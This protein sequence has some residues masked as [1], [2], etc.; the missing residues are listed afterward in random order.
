[1]MRSYATLALVGLGLL[2]AGC[3]GGA[4]P[5]GELLVYCAAALRVPVEA[6]AR[7]YEAEHGV[8]VQLQYGGS[9]TLL[10]NI[11][12]S[13][14]GDLYI[15]ADDDYLTLAR[16]KGLIDEQLLL[17]VMRPVLA[18]KKDGGP[19]VESLAAL[20]PGIK[21]ALANP[22]T[23]AV[24]RLTREALGRDAYAR[25]AAR[26]P[27][28]KETVTEV[29]LAVKLG[30]ADAGIVWDATVAQMPE[31]R[32]IA[33]PELKGQKATVSAGVLRTSENPT[34]AL[35][36]ARYLAAADKG[37]N[38]F[39]DNGYETAEGDPWADKPELKLM[40]GAMLR[41]AVEQTLNDFEQREDV[42]IT[43]V[44][45]GCGLLTAQMKASGPP[46]A[47]FACDGCFLD[48]RYEPEI[49]ALFHE[50]VRVS[51]NDIV[52]GVARGNPRGIQ[53]LA[54]LGRD[55]LR[56]GVGHPEQSALGR[57][58]ERLLK[59]AKLDEALRPNVRVE[60]AT[61][62]YLINQLRVGS[63]DAV[64]AYRSNVVG[65]DQLEAVD[66]PL[67]SAQAE[68]PFVIARSCRYPQ[69]TRRLLDRIRSAESQKRFQAAG[70]RW[71]G[72]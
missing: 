14:K 62:D 67:A 63:L 40:C 52:I 20:P 35:R 60:S 29:A 39:R 45:N 69:L 50:P 66:I 22:D 6:A 38:D 31:L 46:D 68:Q 23:A 55:G 34:A 4:A 37:Q 43:R 58:T 10:A 44:Y 11:E 2:A 26:E 27:A 49:A 41:P 13:K 32:A 19:A 53:K 5:K 36:F 17:A 21:L 9:Q 25:L 71:A 64:I 1:M 59:E 28:L 16:G 12:L 42:T 54:D 33:V 51:R 24:G 61:G 65:A 3:G 47:Y 30:A 48:R 70:F 8:R 57:L 56:L 15:P 72:G 7:R 18:V